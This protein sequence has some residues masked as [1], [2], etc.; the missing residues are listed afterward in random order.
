MP[1]T[2]LHLHRLLWRS[3]FTQRRGKRIAANFAFTE[4]SEVRSKGRATLVS[5]IRL[6]GPW[7][8]DLRADALPSTH[9]L[10][11]ER[12]SSPAERTE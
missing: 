8:W 3:L 7:L 2:A 1:A 9:P 6:A 11:A 12:S 10:L 5:P 4:F